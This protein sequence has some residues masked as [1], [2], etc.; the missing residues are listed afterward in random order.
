MK[1][2][3]NFKKHLSEV[4]C[5]VLIAAMALTMAACGTKKA[6]DNNTSDNPGIVS[7]TQS[8]DRSNELGEGKT[9]FDFTVVYAD[10]KE[11]KFLINTDEE[12]V[13]AALLKVKLIEGEDSA[14]GLFVKKVNGV[15][16]DFDADGTYWAFYVNGEYASTGVDQ[17]K[18][19]SGSSYM[20]KVEK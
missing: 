18:I 5:L 1:M 2:N 13:G 4:V 11:E 14:Y 7:Q 15:T 8:T 12:T 10:G 16:A 3:L 19:E 9:K 17:T 20:F 6:E